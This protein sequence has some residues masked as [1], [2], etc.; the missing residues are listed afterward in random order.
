MKFLSLLV[1]FCMIS[2]FKFETGV[3]IRSVKC[4]ASGKTITFTSCYIKSFRGGISTLNIILNKTRKISDDYLVKIT[5]L[6]FSITVKILMFHF[7]PK[8]DLIIEKENERNGGVIVHEEKLKLQKMQWC[9]MLETAN[10]N[11]AYWYI[12]KSLM[13]TSLIAFMRIC[14]KVGEFKAMNFSF[15]DV[16]SIL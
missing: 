4:Y 1:L 14:E 11:G 7:C 15:S 13:S 8:V 2:E 6:I 16:P 3:R 5:C 10:S 12:Q 9:K